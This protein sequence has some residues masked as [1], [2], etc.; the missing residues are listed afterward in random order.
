MIQKDRPQLTIVGRQKTILDGQIVWYTTKRSPRA[1]YAR[2]EVRP[3]TGLIV[4]IPKSYRPE[5]ALELLKEKR[6]WILSKLVKFGYLRPLMAEKE[7]KSGDTIPYLGHNLKVITRR[8]YG[9]DESVEL[10]R[11][12]LI[13]SI[14]G[15]DG[16]LHLVLERWYRMQAEV[17]V[18]EKIDKLSTHLGVKY[19]RFIIRGQKT[20]WGS[21]SQKGN[22][23]FNWKL[24]MAPE[25]VID[26]VMIHE[27][28][29]LKELN[30]SRRFWQLVAEHCPQWRKHKK[31]LNDHTAEL[32]GKLPV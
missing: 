13:V 28:A 10:V 19:N 29:H 11:N 15:R 23:N 6:Q 4:V 5:K 32:G 21:C 1:K 27:L 14:R 30:H 22:L 25:P 7:L 20:R 9:N 2:L 31:W 8:C 12:K 26:Y 17:L 24:I 18:K 3:E 16:R